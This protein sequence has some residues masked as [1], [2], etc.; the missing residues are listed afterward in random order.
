VS[1][2]HIRALRE[3]SRRSSG[4]L[5]DHS[6][7][8]QEGARPAARRRAD[9]ERSSR[10]EAARLAAAEASRRRGPETDDDGGPP[11]LEDAQ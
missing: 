3:A 2:G 9:L 5:A 8:R 7:R 10:R 11:N 1:D 6:P 4:R